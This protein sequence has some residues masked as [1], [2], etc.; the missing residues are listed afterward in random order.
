MPNAIKIVINMSIDL[1]F[2][3]SWRFFFLGIGFKLTKEKTVNVGSKVGGL[4][5]DEE[6]D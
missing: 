5:Y 3:F 2:I 4:D 1:I 6:N